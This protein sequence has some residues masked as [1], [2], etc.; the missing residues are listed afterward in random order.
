MSRF[1][2]TDLPFDHVRRIAVLRGGGLGDLLFAMPAIEALSRT[3]P[4]AEVLLLGSPAHA[5]LLAGRRSPVTRV[6]VLP[7]ARG[8]RERAAGAGGEGGVEDFRERVRR[9]GRIDLGVQLHGGGRFSNPFLLALDPRHSI[10]AATE[11]AAAL[12]RSIPYMY[13][14]HEVLRG[15][16]IAALAGA[17]P[18]HLEPRIEVGG[19]DALAVRRHLARDG[20]PLAVLHPGASDPRRRWPGERFAEVAVGLLDAGASVRLIG[21]EGDRHLCAAIARRIEAERPASAADITVL[22]GALELGDTAALLAEADVVVANDSG[23]RHLA[24]AVGA[25]TV[26]IFWFGNVVN[27]APFSRA[28]HRVHMSFVVS[29]PTCGVDV[30]QVGWTAERCP[31]DDSLVTGVDAA[32]VLEDAL[33]LMATSSPRSGTRP[34][35]GSRTRRAG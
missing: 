2:S 5:A 1:T 15:L 31:H 8:V 9:A 33:Q 4:D 22:A 18:V 20:G 28:R 3:Y 32:S 17:E 25:P 29:C 34:V 23:P 26:G 35:H 6:E 14:Q 11:D 16:E 7:F 21:D 13:Y 19:R 27:A 12:E 30:T 10:G 24:Q